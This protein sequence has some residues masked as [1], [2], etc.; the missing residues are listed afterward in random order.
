M[1]S[2]IS[3]T[4]RSG[5]L[6]IAEIFTH[7][8]LFGMSTVNTNGAIEPAFSGIEPAYR[9]TTDSG[10]RLTISTFKPAAL[11]RSCVA[12][13]RSVTARPFGPGASPV[14]LPAR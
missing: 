11:V 2:A 12:P 3:L 13:A 7:D 14:S 1:C 8:L 5:S 6:T 10:P 9:T 4:R